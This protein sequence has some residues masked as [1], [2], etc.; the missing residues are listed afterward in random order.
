MVKR[1]NGQNGFTLVE[2]MVASCI[3]GI[4]LSAVF[5]VFLTTQR[6]LKTAM[7]E[8]ELSLA[9]RELRDKLL[10]Q[11][12]PRVQG[13]T[14]AGL[15]SATNL[16]ENQVL[17]GFVE[18]A[19]GGLGS[20]L[21]DE[22]TQA[23]RL[24][25]AAEDEQKYLI[26]EWAPDKDAHRDWLRPAALGLATESLAEMLDWSPY[27]AATDLTCLTLDLCLCAERGNPDG[28]ACV[29][30][31]RVTIPLAGKIQKH[32]ERNGQGELSY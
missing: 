22:R 17:H 7:S 8:A 25:L 26:N 11:I 28:S 4:V 12:S 14:Y 3:I 30:R 10:F 21:G 5:S 20:S 13:V 31:E 6:L 16:N 19:G 27:Q 18:M 32:Q 9:A 24:V 23:I 29:R 1:V 2:L 15:L